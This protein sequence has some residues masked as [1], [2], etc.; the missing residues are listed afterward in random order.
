MYCKKCGKELEE[1]SVFCTSCGTK[2]NE[3]K[4]SKENNANTTKKGKII[5]ICIILVGLICMGWSIV[6]GANDLENVNSFKTWY[7]DMDWEYYK[8]IQ[9][10]YESGELSDYKHEQAFQGLHNSTYIE[11]TQNHIYENPEKYKNEQ[12]EMYKEE[13]DEMLIVPAA[14]LGIVFVVAGII[15]KKKYA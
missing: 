2:I 10:A 12:L 4:S 14:I 5:S 6:F 11:I 9:E 3:N 7:D 15:I 8:E 13:A 1:D